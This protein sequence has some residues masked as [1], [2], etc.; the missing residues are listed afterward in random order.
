MKKNVKQK[1]GFRWKMCLEINVYFLF[2]RINY[3]LWWLI[4]AMSY[5]R[6]FGAKRRKGAT[7]KPAKLWLFS[8]F[9]WRPFAP[10]HESTRHSMRCVFGYCLSYLCLARRKVAMQ[11]TRQN[12]LL[13]GCRL[14]TFSRLRPENTF[15]RHDI[16][17]P[18]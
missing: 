4:C 9:A 14:A 16:K 2:T 13:A 1:A 17:Q 11:K 7:R 10:P 18:P 6:V 15:I 3:E 12:N 8:V 5:Y